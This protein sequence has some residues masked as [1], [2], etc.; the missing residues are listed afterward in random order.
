VVHSELVSELSLLTV[1]SLWGKPGMAKCW[2]KSDMSCYK[3]KIGIRVPVALEFL[4]VGC[5]FEAM[6]DVTKITFINF[7]GICMDFLLEL[8]FFYFKSPSDLK[9][10]S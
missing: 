10:G 2:R 3:M 7:K 5:H 8:N 4:K 9:T 1:W 6:F